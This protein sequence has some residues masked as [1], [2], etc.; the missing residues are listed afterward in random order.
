MA[1]LNV[2]LIV[3]KGTTSEWAASEYV[4]KAGEWGYDTEAKIAKIGDGVSVWSALP[5]ANADTNTTYNLV[6]GDNNGELKL[7]GSDGTNV[8]AKVTGLGSAAYTEASAYATAAQGTKADTALQQNDITSG[9]ANG[10]IAVKGSDVAVKG[11]GSAAY[12]ESN[13]YATAAQGAKADTAVQT[14]AGVE[15]NLVAFGAG[16]VIKDSGKKTSDFEAA[17]TAAG[18]IA[19]HNSAG[20]AHSDIRSEITALS[21]KVSGRTTSYVFQNKE[22]PTYT[23]AIGKTGSFKVGDT[24]L[25][26]DESISDQWVTAAN[27]EE[28]YYE[29]QDIETKHPSLD[30]YATKVELEAVE[31]KA[32]AAQSAAEAAQSTADGA[33]SAAE[34][35]QATA[36]TA[37][38]K[39][40][41]NTTEITNIKNGTTVVGA[42]TKATQDGS[43]NEITAT[44]ATKT[45]L[46]AVDGKADA[47]TAEITKIK[48]GTTIVAK[49]TGDKNG[50]DITTTY[51]T[52][53][54]LSEAISGLPGAT[55]TDIKAGNEAVDVTKSGTVYTVTHKDYGTGNM[56]TSGSQPYLL[57]SITVDKGHVT[58]I[59]AI[60]LEAA[61][62]ALGTI[63][64][65]GGKA[66][67][68][69]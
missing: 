3:R 31:G 40:D 38:G 60:G 52:K 26:K 34:A 64:L 30:G 2:E 5:A 50:A 66:D 49:A 22:D 44:Y 58:A 37:D 43:G 57:N 47:N 41:A 14:V 25:F 4:L 9:S 45:E 13:A 15:N 67:G 32:D 39:A 1:Q 54:E 65:N 35:A 23:E 28:P 36:S 63:I 6:A 8:T 62:E 46:S 12:T 21:E 29:F 11:L 61:L 53:A 68:T 17:G 24:I 59:N 20:D 27:E 10:T 55:V 33:Q 51:A 18:L 56:E 16:N 7:T 19:T 42:A 69:Y 48:D